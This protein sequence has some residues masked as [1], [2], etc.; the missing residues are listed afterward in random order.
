LCS[1]NV[2]HGSD[3]PDNGKREIGKLGNLLWPYVSIR[4][5]PMLRTTTTWFWVIA[6]TSDVLD[7]MV[8]W[9]LDWQIKQMSNLSSWHNKQEQD[10]YNSKADCHVPS[11]LDASQLYE[12]FLD[13]LFMTM[14]DG[15]PMLLSYL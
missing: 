15:K 1:R 13:L 4:W 11:D 10:Y 3:S 12:I 8:N 9:Q 6:I 7:K 5:F 2:V 14:W